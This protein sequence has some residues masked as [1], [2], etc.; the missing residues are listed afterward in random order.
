[1]RCAASALV[2]SLG[3]AISAAAHEPNPPDLVALNS[4]LYAVWG[5]EIALDTCR[6]VLN[7][8]ASVPGG[9]LKAGIEKGCAGSWAERLAGWRI[10]ASEAGPI[11]MLVD[12]RG[13]MM[14]LFVGLE[15]GQDGLIGGIGG[16]AYYLS[17]LGPLPR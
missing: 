15:T 5:G 9:A 4:G 7:G 14:G 1:M 2:L 10:K 11:L 12:R 13:R 3:A 8:E 17:W 6:I 16:E